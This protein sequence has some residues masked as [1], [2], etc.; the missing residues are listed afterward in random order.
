MPPSVLDALNRV[1]S[2]P[3][4]SEKPV[5]AMAPAGA[6]KADTALD[7]AGSKK[8]KPTADKA[9]DD[10]EG[11]LNESEELSA[12]NKKLTQELKEMR[13]LLA[14]A[15]K[16]KRDHSDS[17]QGSTHV[18][19]PRDRRNKTQR[20]DTDEKQGTLHRSDVYRAMSVSVETEFF[21]L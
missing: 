13:A 5:P 15:E 10:A 20:S 12:K 17:E 18:A 11:K 21:F 9:T 8:K 4:K 7:V 2:A 16:S 19:D 3:R 6:A 14:A 1:H